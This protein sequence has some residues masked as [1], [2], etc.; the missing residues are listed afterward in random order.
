MADRFR[1]PTNIGRNIGFHRP[2]HVWAKLAG[3]PAVLWREGGVVNCFGFPLMYNYERASLAINPELRSGKRLSLGWGLVKGY[4]IEDA[5][6]EYLASRE[7]R[8]PFQIIVGLSGFEEC[9]LEWSRENCFSFDTSPKYTVKEVTEIFA[10]GRRHP[11]YRNQ[12]RYVSG[13]R[14]GNLTVSGYQSGSDDNRIIVDLI[15]RH[16]CVD[17]GLYLRTGEKLW[18]DRV[19]EMMDFL[20]RC[21]DEEGWFWDC[22]LY[23]SPSPRDLS[24]S[25]MPSSA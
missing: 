13:L 5:N 1:L 8:F 15:P 25:R 7:Y 19:F 3:I 9:A 11:V 24:T 6:E 22:L 14:R 21:Q 23:T 17:Y 10:D 4:H 20:L 2:H 12:R 18:K 16:A